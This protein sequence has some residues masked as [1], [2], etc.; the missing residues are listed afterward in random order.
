MVVN[1]SESRSQGRVHVPWKD[2]ANRT[3]QLQDVLT[4]EKFERDGG[5]MQSAGL[6]VDLSAW[7]FYFLHLG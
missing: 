3:W 6:Y 7:E 5:E 2:L 1:L 4:G